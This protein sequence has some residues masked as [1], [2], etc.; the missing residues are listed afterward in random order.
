[1]AAFG[2]WARQSGLCGVGA[3]ST[4]ADQY[5]INLVEVA[6]GVSLGKELTANTVLNGAVIL[7]GVCLARNRGGPTGILIRLALQGAAPAAPPDDV[8]HEGV[9]VVHS[10][11][12]LVGGVGHVNEWHRR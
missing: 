9:T 12:D 1:M 7:F 8:G 11:V 2:S 3:N 10:L 4:L 5:L 6:S